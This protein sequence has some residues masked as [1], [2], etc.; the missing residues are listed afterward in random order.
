ML[1]VVAVVVTVTG[2]VLYRELW[3]VVSKARAKSV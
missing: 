2:N 3:C 1:R